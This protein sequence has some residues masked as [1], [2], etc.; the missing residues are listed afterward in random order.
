MWFGKVAMVGV[1]NTPP[2]KEA[3]NGQTKSMTGEPA[4]STGSLPP[5]GEG[6]AASTSMQDKAFK[7][8]GVLR[9]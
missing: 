6:K 1:S 3:S 8:C 7:F 4:G 9:A 5:L 2:A